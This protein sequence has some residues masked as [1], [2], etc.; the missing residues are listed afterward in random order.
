MPHSTS[1]TL[2]AALALLTCAT[3][4][5]AEDKPQPV[6]VA[7]K[8]G[9]FVEAVPPASLS[10]RV[11]VEVILSIELDGIGVPQKVEVQTSAGGEDAAM[12]DGPAVAAAREFRFEPA[13]V[14]G[15]PVPSRVLYR[16]R[17]VLRPPTEPTTAAV[18]EPQAPE[19]PRVPFGGQ[20]RR[21]GDRSPLSGI[22]ITVD[23]L[24]VVTDADGRFS[25]PS[26]PIGTRT[27]K[28]RSG[29]IVA[30][31]V[32]AELKSGKRL[33]VTW[34]AAAKQRF[35]STVR[36]KRI[37]QETVE[38]TLTADEV[39][40]IPGTQ[41]DTLKAVQNLPGVARSS[42]GGGQLA[43]WGSSP[44]DTRTYVDGVPI[45]ILFHFGGLRSTVNSEVIDDLRFLPG[46]YSADYGR[47]T[48]GVILIETRRPKTEGI[49]GFVQLDLIDGSALIEGK[50]TK[51]LS[52]S[53][54]ARRS[55]LDV[56]I[57]LFTTS[58]F[59]LSPK[60][61]DYQGRLSWRATP[62]DDV[63]VFLF[64]SDDALKVKLRNA[65]PAL[66][67]TLDSH[68]FYH[69]ALVRWT[70][71]LPHGATLTVTPSL[72]YDVPIQ[73]NANFGN[74]PIH[75]DVRLVS[76]NLRAVA[77]L[78]LTSW[79]RL[80]A[81]L[82][83]EGNRWSASATSPTTGQPQEGDNSGPNTTS[84]STVDTV[85]YT[86]AIAPYAIA[87]FHF[88]DNKLSIAPQVRLET[89]TFSDYER[90]GAYLHTYVRAEPRLQLRYQVT[91][92]LAVK[93]AIGLYNQI[94]DA[95]VLARVFGSPGAKPLVA[96]HYVLGLEAKPWRGGF[97]QLQGFYKDIYDNVV[98]GES[99]TQPNFTNNGRGRVYGA[100][101][102]VKQELF[103]GFYGWISYTLSRSE[104]K[105]N[106]D[107]PWRVFSL[108][109]THIFTLIA[110]YKLP[111]GYQ[112]GL[113]MRV[114]TGN[115]IT[116][117]RGS[118]FSANDGGYSP[119]YGP[120]YSSRLATFHQ[121][122]IRFDKAWTFNRWKL[123]V[124]LDIQNVYYAKNPEGLAYNYNFSQTQPITG[125][126]FLPVLGIRGDF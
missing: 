37:V 97:I 77:R 89:Y 54:S 116:P 30:A 7:P 15:K 80:D 11:E 69:R 74:V 93:A 122:D 14:D 34:Y 105:D 103:H 38:Y 100:D 84:F 22:A 3:L 90:R 104:R 1:P 118:Y 73:V 29:D 42:F 85:F 115:P 55:W 65:D 70:H 31:D 47:G 17:Y 67:A 6:F 25:F 40:H 52:F 21:A 113:R 62:R 4:A 8:L 112:V 50:L 86:H 53:L 44:G 24:E 41:G 59:Q 51:K 36:G 92:K 101:L 98:R 56:F 99:Q 120:T 111:K 63:D 5:R 117:V 2:L 12:Y 66:S 45:P 88:F 20:I 10:A 107:Q 79:L 35:A 102:L 27:F 64:G 23:E 76:Y 46:G 13:T 28:L 60:Y 123:S 39:K 96:V 95:I 119:L 121:L 82:D 71:R 110:S 61:Y 49:H 109:Q 126:P 83:F 57:P 94:P 108:D 58:D 78:P 16:Y 81:G 48:G 124:Y 72:G 19:T 125:L 26:V 33:E 9:H 18:T 75:I 43:V 68:N 87:D 114:V 91:P 106:A 32:R